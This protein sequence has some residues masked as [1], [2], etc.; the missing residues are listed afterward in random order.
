MRNDNPGPPTTPTAHGKCRRQGK[1]GGK[2]KPRKKRPSAQSTPPPTTPTS[3]PTTSAAAAAPPPPPSPS[4]SRNRSAMGMGMGMGMATTRRKQ[5]PKQQQKPQVPLLPQ[6]RRGGGLVTMQMAL[7]SAPTAA[8]A[9]ATSTS[10]CK[11]AM[12]VPRVAVGGG[13]S[14]T[15]TSTS[16]SSAASSAAEQEK[17]APPP[18]KRR[19]PHNRT[20]KTQPV[21]IPIP[22][23]Q[24]SI[25]VI[26]IRPD[27]LNWGKNVKNV[28]H[29]H[30]QIQVYNMQIPTTAMME[31]ETD[32]TYKKRMEK[33]LMNNPSKE[34]TSYWLDQ[35]LEKKS[36]FDSKIVI[37]SADGPQDRPGSCSWRGLLPDDF[38]IEKLLQDMAEHFP[39]AR[40]FVF[41]CCYGLEDERVESIQAILQDVANKRGETL[42]LAGYTGSVEWSDGKQELDMLLDFIRFQGEEIKVFGIT[43]KVYNLVLLEAIP[44]EHPTRTVHITSTN[45]HVKTIV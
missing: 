15:S 43:E 23:D 39:E 42:W 37:L 3:T 9:A 38:V 20:P 14:S 18:A 24:I 32:V 34:F 16:S 1:R 7:L 28:V 45:Q 22:L 29:H 17:E 40:L 21:I 41:S 2:R 36:A 13:C 19:R 4:P 5:L 25:S 30:H 12:T 31:P 33:Y 6:K 10:T 44:T 11:A 8:T 26:S 27:K 35:F